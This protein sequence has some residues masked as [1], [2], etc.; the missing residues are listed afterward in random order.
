MGSEKR[1]VMLEELV[2]SGKADSFALYGLANEYMAF[3]RN[4]D[5]LRIFKQL[6]S[7]DPDYVPMYLI[8]GQMLLNLGHVNEAR[9][10]LESG[11]I[12]AREK[13]QTHALSE[14]EQVMEQVPPPPSLA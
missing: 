1:L 12:K 5:A 3:T 8:C 2:N 11:I 9:E 14:L 7:S 4:D 10:W 6:R 13:N